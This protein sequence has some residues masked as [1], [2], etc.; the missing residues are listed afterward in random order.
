MAR[1]NRRRNNRQS[2]RRSTRH[3]GFLGGSTGNP[4]LAENSATVSYSNN[5]GGGAGW[6]EGKYGNE[7]Q[8]YNSV[9]DIGSKTLGNSFT[10]LPASQTP[11]PANLALIQSAGARRRGRRGRGR[12]T[13]KRGGFLMGEVIN[14]AVVP[15]GLLALQ[16]RYGRRKSRMN[17]SRRSRRFRR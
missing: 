6:V 12:M 3:R 14:Q 2:R 10:I 7:D 4:P 1:T 16:N 15:F 13:K 5:G 9:F 8:Q 11:T 17:K